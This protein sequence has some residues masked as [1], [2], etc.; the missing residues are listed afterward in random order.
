MMT[1]KAADTLSIRACRLE[2][3]N[4]VLELWRQADATPSMTDTAD[5]LRRAITEN[6]SHVL[7]TEVRGRLVGSIIGTFDGWRGNIYRLVVHPNSRRQGVARALVAEVE[8][9]LKQQGAKR[10]TALVE[11]DHPGAMNFWEGV[12]YQ[13]DERIVRRVRTLTVEA[14]PASAEQTGY[15]I[16]KLALNDGIHLSEIRPSDKAAYLAHLKEKEIYDHTLRIPYPYTEADAEQWLALAAKT[17]QQHGQL[18]NWAIRN[19]DDYLIGGIG[20][21]GLIP[22]KPHRAEIGYWLAK[23]CWGRGIM[24]A[25]VRKICAFA[26]SEWKLVKITAHVF[27]FNSASAR[28]LEKCGFEQEGFLKKHY[29]K[30]GQSVDAKV[31]GLVK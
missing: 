8:R 15:G 10:I 22:S 26:F 25:V 27:A 21:H 28:V 11:R 30:S 18:V 29:L 20:F 2:D 24:T 12:G 4:G 31:Y 13:V 7:V 17:T 1:E 6:P 19:E 14:L 3:I 9:K 16:M 5:D 23:P